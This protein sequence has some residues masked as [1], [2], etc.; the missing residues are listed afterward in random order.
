MKYS[1]GEKNICTSGENY[2]IAPNAIVIGDVTLGVNASIW[3]R[4]VVRGDNE[5]IIIGTNSQIQ[6]CCVLHADPGFP[7]TIGNQTSIGH[8]VMLHGCFIGH[9]TLVGIGAVILNG[10]KIGNNCLIGARTLITENKEIPDGS[11]VMG[12]PGRVIRKVTS[13]DK[14]LISYPARHYVKRWKLYKKSMKQEL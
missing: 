7:L 5:Q 6:D 2:W 8:M 12:T 14:K 1:L 9:K 3:F 10:A 13:E 4:S 11:V